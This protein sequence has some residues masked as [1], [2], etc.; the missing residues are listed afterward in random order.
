MAATVTESGNFLTLAL[1]IQLTPDPLNPP[2]YPL[3]MPIAVRAV[4]NAN[5]D[6][7]YQRAGQ[8]TLNPSSEPGFIFYTTPSI[9]DA[10]LGS[11]TTFK[12]NV[13]S[14]G[15]F[16]DVIRFSALAYSGNLQY[17]F[18]PPAVPSSGTTTL[19]VSTASL[20]AGLYHTIVIA[21]T[22]SSTKFE[23]AVAVAV[24]SGP[25]PVSVRDDAPPEA[26]EHHY[27]FTLS[28]TWWGAGQH[29]INGFNV[30]FGPAVD[31]RN[32]C[33]LFSDGKKLWLAGDDGLTWSLAGPDLATPAANSQCT[34]DNFAAVIDGFNS[35]WILGAHIVFKPG[36]SPVTNKMFVR[37]SN[38]AGFDSG[39]TLADVKRN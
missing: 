32:A 27:N 7:G 28:G 2:V 3:E 14:W 38:V 29:S 23:H 25:P 36:F 19:T 20:A 15:G 22:S 9:R 5:V 24:E 17:T 39:Y 21:G 12:L 10:A 18:D 6:T 16:N 35:G 1:P 13:I 37:A 11:S 30:L 34:V 8:V 26:T 33:W 4:N 31:G